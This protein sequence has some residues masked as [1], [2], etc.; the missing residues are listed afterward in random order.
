MM[1]NINLII[2]I[3]FF[4]NLISPIIIEAESPSEITPTKFYQKTMALLDEEGLYHDEPAWIEYYENYQHSPLEFKSFSSMMLELSKAI[5]IVGGK[6]SQI[7]KKTSNINKKQQNLFKYPTVQALQNGMIHITLPD[8][9]IFFTMSNNDIDITTELKKYTETVLNYIEQNRQNIKGIV[10]D[11][12]DNFGGSHAILFETT[13][14][15]FSDGNLLSFYNN[16]EEQIGGIKIENATLSVKNNYENTY[17]IKRLSKLNVPVAVLINENTA[18]A[19]EYLA[20][21]I[22]DSA[23]IDSKI[24]GKPSAGYTSILSGYTLNDETDLL[25]STAYIKSENDTLYKDDSIK[26]DVPSKT[27]L[28]DALKWLNETSVD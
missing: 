22:K 2:V 13:N 8:T 12:R 23:N 17:H 18:S 9:Y 1:K 28:E 11:L 21:A 3:I 19:A 6:H 24:F 4:L 16:K 7:I 25:L 5:K 27:P 10:L 15:L 20:I 26:P 14:F